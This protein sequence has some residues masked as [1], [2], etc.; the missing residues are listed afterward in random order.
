[1]SSRRWRACPECDWV[2]ALPV[3]K[4]GESAHCPRCERELVHRHDAPAQRILAYAASA[5]VMLLLTLPFSFLAFSMAGI[6]QEIVLFDAAQAMFTNDWPIL[7]LLIALTIVILPGLFL[8]TIVYLYASIAMRTKLPGTHF[9][10]RMLSGLK[11]WLMTDVFLLGVLIS[12]G[13]LMGM[14]HVELGWS[15]IA[16]CGYVFFLVKTVSLVD[17]DWLWFA[18][19]HEPPPPVGAYT[20]ATAASQ[21]I[22]GCPTCGLLNSQAETSCRRC[23]AS[24]LSPSRF[25]LQATWA[26][27]VAATILYIPANL[28]PMMTTVTI[29]GTIY[30]TILGGVI[31]LIESESYVI[32]TIIFTASFIVPIAKIIALSYLSWLAA[33]PQPMASK[34]RMR[35]YRITE[36]IGRWSM[37][38]VFVVAITVALMQAGLILSIYPGAAAAAFAA[39]VIITM[40]AAMTFD[41]R[42]LWAAVESNTQHDSE[43][44]HKQKQESYGN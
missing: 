35:L 30:S 25:R 32:A 16:F 27:I 40:I 39:V 26:L 6:Q 43:V 20:G 14:A 3:L 22:A 12:I 41:P 33:H 7:A 38:D 1:M 31:Q 28:Y 10:A 2:T 18:L 9:L 23:H 37:I 17:A 34:R 5:L 15:F 19:L 24:I 44:A 42:L 13:K 11:P 8:A 29:G 4:A 36:I 21:G